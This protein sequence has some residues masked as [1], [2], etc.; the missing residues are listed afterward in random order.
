MS[1]RG[2][3]TA[4]TPMPAPRCKD[5]NKH[6]NYY[7]NRGECI[8]SPHYMKRKCAKSCKFCK[9]CFI[10]EQLTLSYLNFSFWRER[11]DPFIFKMYQI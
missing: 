6:C 2:E 1:P 5:Y 11:K 9:Y 10:N 3:T 8:K 4:T 7:V